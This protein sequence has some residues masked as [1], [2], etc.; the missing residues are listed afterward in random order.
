MPATAALLLALFAVRGPEVLRGRT[1][2]HEEYQWARRWLGGLPPSCR[3]AYV[4]F[5]GR[6]N[7]FLPTYV[8]SPP[9][10]VDAI[11]RLDGREAIDM[12]AVLGE[13]GCTYYVRSSL[14]SSAEG[15]PVC[16]DVERQLALDPVARASFA[17]VPSNRGLPYDREVV[18]VVVAK[19]VG[20]GAP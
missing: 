13:V 20:Y 1:T 9:L 4:G 16:A 7:L 5:A 11:A 12:Q 18:E 3:I 15:R 19:V 10:G 6:R 2:N 14:C 8:V 17:A